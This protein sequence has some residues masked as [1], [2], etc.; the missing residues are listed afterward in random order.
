VGCGFRRQ[1]AGESENFLKI[2]T[3]AKK[4]LQFK[5]QENNFYSFSTKN[6][7]GFKKLLQQGPTGE[8]ENHEN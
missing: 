7:K 1:I 8:Q 6:Q 3:K 4:E 5:L 2:V